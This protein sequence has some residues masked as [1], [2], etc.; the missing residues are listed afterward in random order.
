MSNIGNQLS[1][2]YESINNFTNKNLSFLNTNVYL[3]PI[4]GALLI[5]YASL[6]AP[7]LPKSIVKL[8]DNM[9]VKLVF[10]F[11][12]CYTTT[13]SPI[14][15]IIISVCILLSIQMLAYYESS[16]KMINLINKTQEEKNTNKHNDINDNNSN[17]NVNQIINISDDNE[18]S[19]VS[20]TKLYPYVNNNPEINEEINKCGMPETNP[21]VAE[22][23]LGYTDPDYALY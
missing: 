11:L 4:L 18:I 20:N 13:H 5:L 7:K 12:L 9:V 3:S 16:D 19:G 10:I 14:I 15:A 17:N 23:I 21:V 22:H 2:T 1:E 6:A 8:F